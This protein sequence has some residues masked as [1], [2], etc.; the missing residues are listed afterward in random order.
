MRPFILALLPALLLGGCGKSLLGNWRGT[1]IVPTDGGDMPVDFMLDVDAEKG[2]KVHGDGWF[3]YDGYRFRG[4]MGGTRDG[5]KVAMDLEG[6]YGGYVI[7]LSV[8]G[9]L[10][11]NDDKVVGDCDFF[12]NAGEFSME[13]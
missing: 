9:D 10:R 6:L 7:T 2:D 12:D 5:D 8:D 13:L 3:D 4:D 1:C 11:G